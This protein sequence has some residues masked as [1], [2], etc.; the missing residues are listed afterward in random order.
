MAEVKEQKKT[1]VHTVYKLA[2]GDRVPSVT[3]ILGILN[4]PALLDWAWQMGTQGLDYKAVRDGAADVGSLAHYMI[5]CYLR[6][7]EPDTSEYSAQTIERAENSLIKFW[8]WEKAHNLKPIMLETPLVSEGLGF[9]G[10]I[11][12]FGLVDGQPTLVDF[13][14]GKA[15][16]PEFFYQLAAYEQLLT[17]A[18]QLIEVTRILRIGRTEDEGFEE[19]TIG[20]LDRQWEIFL[21]CLKIYKLQGEIRREK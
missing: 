20:K 2:C 12:F 8:D 10:T 6:R 1:R 15:V 17:E 13:K 19:R 14:T 9:G 3:T 7:E 5:L 4:K 11:D 18:G 16:Y 21:N